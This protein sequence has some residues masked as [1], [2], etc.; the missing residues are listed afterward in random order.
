MK[1]VFSGYLAKLARKRED[2]MTQ[3]PTER[4]TEPKEM[5]ND[6]QKSNCG[7][8]QEK[9]RDLASYPVG[10][11][12]AKA[13]KYHIPFVALALVVLFT[14]LCVISAV[15]GLQPVALAHNMLALDDTPT[16]GNPE[17]APWD[18]NIQYLQSLGNE[19]LGPGPGYDPN[20][21]SHPYKTDTGDKFCWNQQDFT[22]ADR[23]V[24]CLYN[25]SHSAG[26]AWD[27]NMVD[28]GEKVALATL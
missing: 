1:D 8:V 17:A 15:G 14:S 13:R 7:T 20:N 3:L 11:P 12:V 16:P 5:S 23:D 21:C 22:W 6:S 26:A 4:T 19:Q 2:P 27:V 25:P 10:N 28:K 24:T 18:Q 9:E